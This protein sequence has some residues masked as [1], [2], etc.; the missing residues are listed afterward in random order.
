MLHIDDTLT[1]R[2]NIKFVSKAMKQPLLSLKDEKKVTKLWSEGKDVKSL[3]VLINSYEKL[4]ISNAIKFRKFGLPFGDLLQEG[5]VG[6]LKAAYKFDIKMD[7]RFSTYARWWIRS[8]MQE[9]VLK[10]W[11]IV[12]LGSTAIQKLLFFQLSRLK[13]KIQNSSLENNNLESITDK[14]A[15][16]LKIKVSEV[17]KIFER[18][19]KKDLLLDHSLNNNDDD[20][21]PLDFLNDTSLNPDEITLNNDIHGNR[22]RV[23]KKSL[24]AL[25]DKEKHII[26]KRHLHHTPGTLEAIGKDLNISKERV[27]QL[28]SRA[29]LKLKKRILKTENKQD[30][31]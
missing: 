23:I 24:Q 19:I 13:T 22:K 14:I 1:Q 27:R 4:V 11:A 5:N 31:I 29:F 25:N 12:R 30:L 10:N 8:S 7:V 18:V 21:T 15:K 17:E 6:I 9:F 2:A 3:H 20:R 16:D 28:E 26:L